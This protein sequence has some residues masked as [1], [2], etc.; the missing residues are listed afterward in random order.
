MNDKE[1]VESYLSGNSTYKVA[2][3][4]GM[5]QTQIRRI[6]SK[7][8]IIARSTKTDTNK[9]EE[10]IKL[11]S[12][13]ISS[14]KIAK[15]FGMNATTVCRILKRNNF[16]LRDAE[17]N[18]RKYKIN[19]DWLDKID[20]EEK[21]YFMGFMFAD[22]NVRQGNR[23]FKIALQEQDVDIL[24]KFG[25]LIFKTDYLMY[26]DRNYPL[27]SI[28]CK[29]LAERL[30][31]LGCVPN[32]C[33]ICKFPDWLVLELEKHFIRGMFD[34]DGCI[35]RHKNRFVIDFTGNSFICNSIIDI[36]RKNDIEHIIIYKRWPEAN[37]NNMSF[38]INA[39]YDVY[40]FLQYI[41]KDSKIYLDRKYGKYLD[42]I[43]FITKMWE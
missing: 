8:N 34:G 40:K 41:Y 15:D 21:A 31:E 27:L 2:E 16:K 17:E 36:L 11:Y 35:Y 19:F 10:I 26:M 24:H 42:F 20:T 6:L 30:N 37:N 4:F 1:I 22:G 9:E 5:S 29:K 7:N 38:R 13:G 25:K 43:D 33:F 23:Q 28:T 12:D 18:K 39:R 3:L 32:K 14:E